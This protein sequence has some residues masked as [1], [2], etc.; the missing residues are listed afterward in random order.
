MAAKARRR[1]TGRSSQ[2]GHLIGK[3]YPDWPPPILCRAV[4][5]RHATYMAT[6][7]AERSRPGYETGVP[8]LLLAGDYTAT[9]LP[10][11]LEGAVESG[12]QGAKLLTQ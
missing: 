5:E 10:A 8:G 3:L 12:V 9:G 7:E 1:A 2:D 4:T 11:T 6:P